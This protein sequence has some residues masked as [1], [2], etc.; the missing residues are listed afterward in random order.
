MDDGE[1][2]EVRMVHEAANG[3]TTASV[4]LTT[5]GDLPSQ[6]APTPPLVCAA[7]AFRCPCFDGMTLLTMPRDDEPALGGGTGRCTV[8]RC[9][10]MPS[11]P[12]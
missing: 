1:R 8:G 4:S 2:A 5:P 7:S 10:A 11:A 12:L 9:T 6:A 3:G